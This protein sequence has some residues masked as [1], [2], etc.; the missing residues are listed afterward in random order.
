MGSLGPCQQLPLCGGF[1]SETSL[2]ETEFP[3]LVRVRKALKEHGLDRDSPV[4]HPFRLCFDWFEAGE[5]PSPACVVA[6]FGSLPRAEKQVPRKPAPAKKKTSSRTTGSRKPASGKATKPASK[7]SKKT[8]KVGSRTP[9]KTT[10]ASS[11]GKPATRKKSTSAI[12][13]SKSAPKKKMASGG[14]KKTEP[15]K[16]ASG[17]SAKPTKS[18]TSTSKPASKA[19]SSQPAASSAGGKRKGISIVSDKPP[20]PSRPSRSR[21]TPTPLSPHRTQLLGP[22]APKRKPLIPSGPEAAALGSDASDGSRKPTKSPFRKRELQRFREVLLQKR[23][24]LI[25]DISQLESEALNLGND[26]R[27]HT[28]QHMAEQGSDSAE[29]T[30]ALDLAAADRKLIREIDDAIRRIDKGV[31][32][33]CEL[34]GRPIRVER[35]R[36]LPW[37]RYSIDAARQLE[38]RSNPG[39]W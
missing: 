16:T 6:R 20:K 7:S 37:A 22:N 13:A 36:E 19:A 34:T 11:G 31:Y 12:P 35:L 8:A 18:E 39:V 29:Q 5:Y 14:P 33:L 9:K 1:P 30:L 10:K 32:G 24:A 4:T 23:S 27:S 28:P 15:V 17:K 25:G 3:G 38:R 2:L 26:E 21:S